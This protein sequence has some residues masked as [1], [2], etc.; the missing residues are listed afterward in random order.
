[1]TQQP[2]WQ[3]RAQDF[4]QDLVKVD[5]LIYYDGPLLS[6]YSNRNKTK[7]Y[8]FNWLDYDSDYNRWLVL[9]VSLPHLFDYL[10]NKRTLLDIMRQE[11][12]NKL[13]V[14]DMDAEGVCT[15]ALLVFSSELLPEY[16]PVTDSYYGEEMAPSYAAFFEKVQQEF[17][18]APYLAVMRSKAVRFRL[19]P[20]GHRFGSTLGAADIGN[21]LQR[22]TRSIRSYMEVRFMDL[23]RAKYVAEDEQKALSLVLEASGDPRAVFANHGSFE[24]DLAMDTLQLVNMVDND[25]IIWQ[26]QVLQE[27]KRNVFD[28]EFTS[29]AH[30]P[31]TLVNATDE[32][33]RAIFQ[34]ILM[35]ANNLHYTVRTRTAIVEPYKLLKAVPREAQ[36]RVNPPKPKVNID[37]EL[38]TELA[39]VLLELKRGQD[40]TTLTISQLKRALVSVTKADSTTT[41]TGFRSGEGLPIEFKDPIEVTI[42][43]VGEL[44][45]ARY[46]P[47]GIA[48][49]GSNARAA[50]DGVETEFRK[51]YAQLGSQEETGAYSTKQTKILAEF[52]QMIVTE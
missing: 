14:T 24:I 40:P 38:E 13:L 27:Y 22:V 11:Y 45:E 9:E 50:L 42:E 49:F 44:W 28:F 46:D 16:V 5:D 34:P 7:H 31:E 39:N 10:S 33:L 2:G 17:D 52:A 4:M 18:Y 21:F 12:N 8:L 51:L 32:Q 6:H 15:N 19:E 26:R 25:V 37:E 23:F 47:L 48:K 41:Y 30:L 35:I 36:R 1:M 43:R 20:L 3:L 29:A